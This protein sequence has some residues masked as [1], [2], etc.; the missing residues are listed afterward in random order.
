[1]VGGT[2]QS[3]RTLKGFNKVSAARC[4]A[5]SGPGMIW[6]RAVDPSPVRRLTD[7]LSQR[8]RDSD[9]WLTQLRRFHTARRDYSRCSP[10]GNASGS[11]SVG[12]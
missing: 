5:P 8:E 1:M 9:S 11:R 12:V 2:S 6:R 10:A 4:A 3:S 7:T